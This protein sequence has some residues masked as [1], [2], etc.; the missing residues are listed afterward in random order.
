MTVCSKMMAKSRLVTKHAY[1]CFE[2]ARREDHDPNPTNGPSV[3]AAALIGPPI[4]IS[5]FTH[6]VSHVVFF[7]ADTAGTR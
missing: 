5:C 4:L 7:I 1:S 2:A 3:Y 6:S